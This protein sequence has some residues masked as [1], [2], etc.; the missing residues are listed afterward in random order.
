MASNLFTFQEQFK[1][2]TFFL[3]LTQI[4]KTGSIGK[5]LTALGNPEIKIRKLSID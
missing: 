3:N 2:N 1:V 4:E 5:I